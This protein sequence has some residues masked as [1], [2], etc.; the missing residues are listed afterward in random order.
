MTSASSLA[1]P[2]SRTLA[3]W[4]Q[5]LARYGPT[6]LGVGYLF[7]HRLEAHAAWL[8][9]QPLD[10]LS[11][12]VL[13]AIRLEQQR[14]GT[15]T[16]SLSDRL[17]RRLGLALGVIR[18]LL[19]SLQEMSLLEAD[20]AADRLPSG[21]RL[22]ERGDE[23]LRSGLVPSH[24]WKRTEFSFVERLGPTGARLALPHFMRI[25][26]APATP[27]APGEANAPVVSLLQACLEE[28]PTWK[29]TFG[30][31]CEVQAFPV[32]SD[33]VPLSPAD[34]IIDKPERLLVVFFA[35]AQQELL[36]FAARP[37]GWVLLADEPIVRLP[38]GAMTALGLERIIVPERLA[39]TD[40]RKGETWLLAG[41]GYVRHAATPARSV[42]EDPR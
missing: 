2:G 27:W 1:F 19:H 15:P 22:T 31:P 21:C 6:G 26:A 28:T 7:V 30:F 32:F 12:L 5:Q 38:A 39:E 11:L 14:P 4:W 33:S 9:T 16:D 24:E 29:N 34:V 40:P 18:R 20:L 36:G 35:T 42:S 23:A 3:T 41:D 37:E 17:E 10:P 8:V 13:E 25:A